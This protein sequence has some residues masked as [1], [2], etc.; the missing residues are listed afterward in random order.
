MG[1]FDAPRLC[2]FYKFAGSGRPDATGARGYFA[3][4]KIA[5]CGHV[6]TERVDAV[7]TKS[8]R[9]TWR[10]ICAKPRA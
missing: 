9:V 7:L 10:Y 5:M 1:N 4:E 8:P 3:G 6:Q 2:F